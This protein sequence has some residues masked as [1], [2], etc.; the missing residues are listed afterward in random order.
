MLR[1]VAEYAMRSIMFCMSFLAQAHQLRSTAPTLTPKTMHSQFSG[2]LYRVRY[3]ASW[4]RPLKR[5]CPVRL[6]NLH[7]ELNKIEQRRAA[8]QA[9][10]SKESAAVYTALPK[11]LGLK[12]VD[13]LVEALLPYASLALRTR[14]GTPPTTEK[15][16]PASSGRTTTVSKASTAPK[17]RQKTHSDAVKAAVKQDFQ[18]GMPTSK[19]SAKH[20]VNLFTLKK[21]KRKW[22]LTKGAKPAAK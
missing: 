1:D 20:G 7:K 4:Q 5:R 8:L 3:A 21:W 15:K 22:G 19:V 14:F 17:R 6:E 9:Q 2:A 12:N 18:K 11:K 10:I 16:D 13:S